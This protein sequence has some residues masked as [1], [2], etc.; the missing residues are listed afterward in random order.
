MATITDNFS[1]LGTFTITLTSLAHSTAGVG[2][3]STF[4]DNTTNKYLSAN[5]YVKVTSGGSTTANNPV[6]VYL[7]RGDNAN[8]NDDN[9][10]TADAAG[11]FVNT[12]IL[13]VINVNGTAASSSYYGVFDTSSFGPLGPAWGV[14]IVNSSGTTFN[15]T[16]AQFSVTYVG[17]TKTVA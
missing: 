7:S 14:G 9:N 5:V 1:A 8:I 15:G 16:A 10:G 4:L 12:P 2:R 17:V 6:Y 11:T 3:V 13:G